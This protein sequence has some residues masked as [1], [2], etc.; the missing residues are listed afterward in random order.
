MTATIPRFYLRHALPDGTAR[1]AY[2][3]S[4]VDGTERRTYGGED[5]WTWSATGAGDTP[6]DAEWSDDW[7]ITTAPIA[8]L[9]RRRPGPRRDDG[10]TKREQSDYEGPIPPDADDKHAD[11]P[12]RPAAAEVAHYAEHDAQHA[13]W[14]CREFI[15]HY[16]RN[17]APGPDLVEHQDLTGFAPLPGEP[18]PQI[19]TSTWR[20]PPVGTPGRGLLSAGRV[21]PATP[22][23]IVADPSALA[24]F[25]QGAAHLLPGRL[26]GLRSAVGSALAK[27]PNIGSFND[28]HGSGTTHRGF[29]VTVRIPWETHRT[30]TE[31][32]KPTPRSRKTQPVQRDVWAIEQRLDIVV[33]DA[34]PAASLAEALASWDE[35]VEHELARFFPYGDVAACDHC[36]GR[37]YVA[38]PTGGA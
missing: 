37:G 24:V 7:L 35:A 16:T 30:R 38:R 15:A 2:H 22:R 36:A 23:W 21:E 18:P 29:S 34:F 12:E 11:K 1:C 13:C 17:W 25:G 33:P 3:R 4:L 6:I 26:T 31:H 19:D 8:T 27:H 14:T 10:W 9:T 32:V 20:Y 28:F 5:S